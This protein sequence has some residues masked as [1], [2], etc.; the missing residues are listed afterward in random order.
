MFPNQKKFD[1]GPDQLGESP[2][3]VFWITGLSGAGKTTVGERLW[4]RLR[5][6]GRSV[7]F[8]DGDKL[9]GAIAEDLGHPIE[10]RRMSAMRNGRLCRLLAEQ[11]IDVVCATISMFHEVQQW[12]RTHIPGYFEIYLRVPMAEIERRDPKGIYNRARVGKAANVVGIDIAAEEPKAPDLMIDNHGSLDADAA[13]DLIWRCVVE[14]E[15]HAPTKVGPVQFGT[16]A[17]TLERLQAQLKHARILPQVRFSVAQ[18]RADQNTILARVAAMP[19][20]RETLIVRSSAKSEDGAARSEAGKYDSVLGVKGDSSLATAVDN[21][22]ASFEDGSKDDQVFVQPILSKVAIAGVAFTRDP[23]G[24]GPYFIIN[25]DDSSGRTDLVTS[26]VGGDLKTF[27]CL[28]THPEAVP[29]PL[30]PIVRLLRELETLLASDALDIEFAVDQQGILHLLQVRRLTTNTNS[31]VPTADEFESAVAQIACK[32]ELLN[33]PHPYLH[34]SRS[35]F[36]VM[37]DWNPAEIIGL[38]PKS[39]ALTLYQELVTDS[40]WAYQRDNYGYKNLRSFPLMVSFHGMPYIDVRV[41]FNSFVPRDVDGALADRLVNYYIDRLIAQPNLHDKV[42]F[43]IIFSCH[44]FDLPERISALEKHGFSKDEIAGLS[45]SLRRLTN[46]II[47]GETGLWRRDREKIDI[48]AE[49]L[50]TIRNAR[51]DKISRIYWLIEDCKRYG[52][53]PFAGLARAGFIAVQLLRSLVIAGALD[54]SEYAAFLANLETVGS[55]IGRDFASLSKTEFLERYGHLRPGTYDILSP[56]YDEAPDLYFDWTAPRKPEPE[57][58][59]FALSVAQLRHIERL[60]R[61]HQ[62]NHDVLSFIDFIKAG[63]EGREFAKFIFTRSLSDALVL[64]RQLGEEHGITAEDCAFLDF[65]TIRE[66]HHGSGAVAARLRDSISE[67]K[68]RHALTQTLILPSLIKAPEEVY[69]FYLPP[70]QP[71]FITQKSITASTVSISD[72]PSSFA[73]KILF[74]PSADPGFDWIFTRGISGFVT[75]FGGANSHMAIRAGELGIPAVIG[76]GEALFQRWSA[77][78]KIHLDCS[79]HTVQLVG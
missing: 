69:G 58:P 11:G 44:S 50:G 55:L 28:K 34:G 61:E 65:A 26:G 25:Y 33:R 64:I 78:K 52:T 45:E 71:N 40:I 72:P 76:A 54:E 4:G 2:G 12:N 63:I 24:G 38:R 75:Q 22:I 36:G 68:R 66:L 74:I 31:A 32:I 39:L 30:V 15:R 20:G 57:T 47:H 14:G 41:S 79:S 16:K 18:W 73:G 70:T 59:R 77:A 49:R 27:C 42:E 62:L 9:R 60:L 7:I 23:N 53:L 17:E 48:L 37:P 35:V 19:W 13:V 51:I 56:R 8:L 21:V 6:A 67:N 5:A 1:I 43:E 3:R 10:D 29:G 46:R